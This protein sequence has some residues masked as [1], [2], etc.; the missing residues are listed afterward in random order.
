MHAGQDSNKNDCI[1]TWIAPPPPW[2][3]IQ[4][5]T[6]V[7]NLD[8]YLIHNDDTNGMD[9]EIYGTVMDESRFIQAFTL[10]S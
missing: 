9:D 8:K 6:H 2:P 7:H 4:T 10:S 5:A 1:T 3:C